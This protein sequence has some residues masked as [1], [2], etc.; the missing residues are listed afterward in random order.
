ME[1]KNI[2]TVVFDMGQVLIHWTP[3][4][5]TEHMG[6]NEADMSILLKEM[7]QSVEW[8]SLDHGTLTREQA[9][10]RV[11]QRIPERLWPAVEETVFGWWRRPL[12]PMEGMADLVREL[13][14]KGYHLYVLSNAGLDL[15]EY[16]HRIP[17]AECFEG[18]MVSAE[19]K[20]IKPMPAIYRRLAE[21]FGLDLGSCVFIDDAPANIEVAIQTGMNGIQFRGDVARLRKELRELDIDVAEATI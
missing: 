15:R 16:F 12:K 3:F 1:T 9:A 17:G 5:V 20:L 4:A 6:L 21:K 13:K 19:E 18:I 10:A 11:K 2:N 14:Q 8:V 7:F